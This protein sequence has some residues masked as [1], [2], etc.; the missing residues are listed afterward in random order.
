[1]SD[2]QRDCSLCQQLALAPGADQDRLAE[3]SQAVI[4]LGRWQYYQGYCVVV[5]R[6]HVRELHD[7]P[8]NEQHAIMDEV[9]AVSQALARLFQ[10]RKMNVEML[11]NQVPHLHCHLFPRYEHDP[12]HLKPVWLALD[13]GERDDQERRRLETAALSRDE[14]RDRIKAELAR[15]T[16]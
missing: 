16:P 4:L 11:G 12:D 1:M 14:I 10:P 6:R 13:R 7:L 15:I 9:M 2:S 3:F 5:A 8:R